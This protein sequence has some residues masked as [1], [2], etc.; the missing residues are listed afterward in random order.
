MN[1]CFESELVWIICSRISPV[2]FL[3]SNHWLRRLIDSMWVGSHMNHFCLYLYGACLSILK[4][5]IPLHGE[6][7]KER[8]V[9]YSK[10]LL[11]CS[12][13]GSHSSF[14]MTWGWLN[15]YFWVNYCFTPHSFMTE[16]KVK[17]TR[18]FNQ[19]RNERMTSCPVPH[20]CFSSIVLVS[21]CCV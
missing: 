14:G 13:E 5:P 3:H 16:R 1:R 18:V 19:T 4:L 6:K 11:L 20:S 12:T 21:D 9:H 10:C 2:Q 7:K 8:Q 17:R 15:F